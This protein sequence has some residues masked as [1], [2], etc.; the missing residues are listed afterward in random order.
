LGI[1]VRSFWGCFVMFVGSVC[2]G[3]GVVLG[4]FLNRF[5]GRLAGRFE[6]GIWGPFWEAFLSRNRRREPEPVLAMNGK[7]VEKWEF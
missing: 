6:E 5:G 4:S 3:L 2:D 7:R 1:G